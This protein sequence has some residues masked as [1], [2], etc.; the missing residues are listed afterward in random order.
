MRPAPATRRTI[1][2]GSTAAATTMPIAVRT[3]AAS[4]YSVL[5]GDLSRYK[6][7]KVGAIQV[8]RLVERYADYL[9]IGYIAWL[10]ADGQLLVPSRYHAPSAITT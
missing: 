2:S 10:R 5:F 4:Q 1:C 6:L 8:M 7:R 3:P 9:Q